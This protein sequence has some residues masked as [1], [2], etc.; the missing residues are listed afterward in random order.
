[1]KNSTT[2]TIKSKDNRKENTINKVALATVKGFTMEKATKLLEKAF[3]T[4]EN[5]TKEK[6]KA[7]YSIKALELYK[8][9]GFNNFKDYINSFEDGILYGVKYN[10]ANN[11]ANMHNFVWCDKVL[12]AYD[13]NKANLLV[14]YVKKDYAKIIAL[15]KA[16]KISE[17]MKK[18]DIEKVLKKNFGGKSETVKKGANEKIKAGANDDLMVAIAQVNHFI[19]K[20]AEKDGTIAKSWQTILKALEV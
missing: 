1:M 17:T 2:T 19:K 9:K 16:G 3:T 10:Q 18:A 7:F 14:A 20:N 4:S 12:N 6:A 13:S 5:A 15:H 8:E 11:L